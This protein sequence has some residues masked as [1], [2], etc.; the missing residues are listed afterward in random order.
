M[1]AQLTRHNRN[2]LSLLALLIFVG[3]CGSAPPVDQRYSN[4]HAYPSSEPAPQF[5]SVGERAVSIA[6]AQ[7]GVPYRYG[8][9]APSG[10]DCSGLV[11]YSYLRAGKSIPRTTGQLWKNANTVQPSEMQAGD[12]LFFSINGK[13]QHVGMY[14]G[15]D[16]FVHAPSTGKHVQVASLDS[17]FYQNA[18]LRAGRPR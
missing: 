11:H 5:S 13:M 10:F 14:I 15:D 1:I 3:A 7:I 6:V 16:Q 17:D 18:L 12:L 8:G 2:P 4:R 9:Q